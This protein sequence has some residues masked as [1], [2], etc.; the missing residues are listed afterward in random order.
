[1]KVRYE[2]IVDALDAGVTSCSHDSIGVTGHLRITCT[3]AH[4]AVA[5]KSGIDEQ[6]AA[7]GRDHQGGLPTLDI[8]EIDLELLGIP[9]RCVVSG[10]SGLSD[11]KSRQ[12]AEEQ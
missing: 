10:K 8:Y 7:V 6:G 5:R 3:A 11:K 2:Q 4:A 1:M 9:A 12:A